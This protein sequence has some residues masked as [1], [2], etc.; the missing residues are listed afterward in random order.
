M[1]GFEIVREVCC[2]AVVSFSDLFKDERYEPPSD[3][4]C[5]GSG[6]K[7]KKR[8]FCGAA[9]HVEGEFLARVKGSA[10]GMQ[11]DLFALLVLCKLT[12]G[13]DDVNGA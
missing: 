4:G 1:D 12:E 8:E 9:K 7:R 3:S 13:S 2:V 5:A 10:F 11:L 6:Q